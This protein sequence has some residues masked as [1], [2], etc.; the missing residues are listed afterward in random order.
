MVVFLPF[1]EIT[2]KGGE[3]F[4]CVRIC[5]GQETAQRLREVAFVNPGSSSDQLTGHVASNDACRER[6]CHKCEYISE[7]F[8][9]CYLLAGAPALASSQQIGKFIKHRRAGM[10]SRSRFLLGCSR[11]T[12]Q[13]RSTG[14]SITGHW[15]IHQGVDADAR[16]DGLCNT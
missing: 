4:F 16:P 9:Y 5:M 6:N 7:S 15:D 12:G 2:Y 8:M 11:S 14:R 3:P 10:I 13:G 1:A